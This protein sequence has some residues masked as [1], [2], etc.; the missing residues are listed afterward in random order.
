MFSIKFEKQ[1][2]KF[3]SKLDKVTA[4]RIISKIKLLKDEPVPHD[5]KRLVNVPD[6]AFRIRVG[7][8]RVLYR[9]E[10]DKIIVVFTV[11]KRSRVYQ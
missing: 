11:D 9:I 10:K 5:A 6:K 7:K 3:L 1:V 8:F 4:K 2:F